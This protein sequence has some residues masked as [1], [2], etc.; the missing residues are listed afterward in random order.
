MPKKREERRR[1][2]GRR[3]WQG[4]EKKKKKE[5]W[6]GEYKE[7]SYEMREERRKKCP[8]IPGQDLS[9]AVR[10]IFDASTL[11]SLS[12]LYKQVRTMTTTTCIIY[13][14]VRIVVDFFC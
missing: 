10:A 9:I 12:V 5:E 4:E 7:T 6:K 14:P 1:I 3:E 8:H 11:T 13:I 2:R